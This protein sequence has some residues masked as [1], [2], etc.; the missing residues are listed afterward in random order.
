MNYKMI[1]SVIGKVLFFEGIMLLIP[2]FVS[3]H[4]S[5]PWEA[6]A[7]PSL[8][9]FVTSLLMQLPQR[10][11]KDV[12]YAREGFLIAGLSWVIMSV[13]G[14]LPF[15]ISGEIPNFEDALFETISGFTTTG[16][17]ILTD[18]ESL[19]HSSLLWRSFTHFI[20]GMGILVFIS[21]ILNQTS[22]KSINTLKAEVPGHS[23]SKLVPRAKAS[24][25]IL[26]GIYV[27]LTLAEIV[28]L[29]AGGMPLFDSL[30]HALGTA[31]TGGF[32]IK[33]DS[34]ASYSP[35]LQWVITIFMLIFG[36]NLNLYYA[37]LLKKLDI[38]K[39]SNELWV[40]LGIFGVSV[41]AITANIYPIYSNLS[42]SLRLSAFQ[43]SSILTT[44]G[45]AT[46]NY[47]LWPSL[48]K[49]I[50]FLLMFC[51][52]CMGSTAGGLKI[53]RIAVIT[54]V[55][56]NELNRVLRP[57]VIRI[58]KLNGKQLD[59]AAT[60]DI[61]AY[62]LI[63]LSIIF[64]TFLLISFENFDVET[65]LTAAI[66]C[67]N[68]VGPGFSIVGPSG[69]YAAYS[70]FSKI[71]LSFAMLLGRLEIYPVLLMLMPMKRSR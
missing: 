1:A 56:K 45:Y 66:A 67:V 3:F 50:I 46:T 30:V 47:D 55:I 32:G 6:F 24:S 4:Y 71:V 36:V 38:V 11:N 7:F 15:V 40:Y 29:L 8:L 34:I 21:A 39:S 14:A 62:F 48:S 10:G 25:T 22:D 18:V 51:G 44:T 53:S 69:N 59:D 64:A 58:I 13:I 26:Y 52:G 9:A 68:N 42:D 17:S 70:A 43:V 20:G 23:V 19:C 61:I 2:F 54:Q 60:H 27:V 57:R 65:N 37:V 28:L 12:I 16:A 31:G 41:V 49:A 35:Y 33:G 63:Y 5:D